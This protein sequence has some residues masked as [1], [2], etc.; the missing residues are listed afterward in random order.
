MVFVFVGELVVL[1]ES[2][3]I[4]GVQV[5]LGDLFEDVGEVGDIVIVCVLV[6]G[7]CIFLN[8]EYVCCLVVE[9][10][11]VWVNVGGMCCVII[12]W[13]SC[14]IIGDVF[15]D[16]L[17]GELFMNEGVCYEV[18]FVNIV[19][20]V[21]V[22]VDS[23]GGLE[24]LFL[25]YDLCFSMLVVE[26][27]FYDGVEIVCIIGCVYQMMEILVFVCLVFVGEEIIVNDIDWILVCVDCVCLDVVFNLDDIIGMES[28]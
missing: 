11:L 24:V 5:M 22:L 8:V 23:F 25:N 9:N 15:V 27:C 3:I 26:I 2:F 16:I 20:V 7:Q 28:C 13:V 21:Y 17:E 12:I 18:C 4:E 10:D 14:V 19:L 1:C 6:L